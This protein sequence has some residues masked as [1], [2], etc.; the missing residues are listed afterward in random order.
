[1]VEL[2]PRQGG[3]GRQEQ[4]EAGRG[5]QHEAPAHGPVS[6]DGV[7]APAGPLQDH[8]GSLTPPRLHPRGAAHLLHRPGDRPVEPEPQRHA[9]RIEADPV[10]THL[11]PDRCRRV[12]PHAHQDPCPPR[13]GVARD[14]GQ[15]LP[16]GGE[17]RSSHPVRHVLQGVQHHVDIESPRPQP[18]DEGGQLRVER[19]VA[20]GRDRHRGLEGLGARL[21]IGQD[22]D[23]LDTPLLQHRSGLRSA[24]Q[25]A[26]CDRRERV[27]HGLVQQP[28][29]PAHCSLDALDHPLLSLDLVP[30]G[31]VAVHPPGVA[32][33]DEPDP[34]DAPADDGHVGG[35]PRGRRPLR[36]RPA[37]VVEHGVKRDERQ[38]AHQGGCDA[39]LDEGADQARAQHRQR[40][41]LV[42]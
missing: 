3:R 27:E 16:D 11:D 21:E 23:R 19:H 18:V 30:S 35:D 33:E 5:R 36:Q 6:V 12:V 17:D 37:G 20:E 32:L 14:V 40:E 2:Q 8:A 38:Y 41:R 7:A 25:P 4:A 10:V 39:H 28:L 34:D 26:A 9:S 31:R 1:M 29:L 42:P 24:A 15:G 13:M 22:V